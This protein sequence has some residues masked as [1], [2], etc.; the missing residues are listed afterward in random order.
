MSRLS[1]LSKG[2]REYLQAYWPAN[3]QLGRPDPIP[4]KLQVLSDDE[5]Q[6]AIAA[7]HARLRDLKMEV[8]QYT[9]DELE[10]ETSVQVLALACRDNDQ[11]ATVSFAQDA[12]DLRQNSTPWE[13]GEVVDAWRPWQERRNP[14]RA[15]SADEER[16]IDAAIKK[17]AATTL[18]AFGADTLVS[19]MISS[20]SRPPT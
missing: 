13:R 4:M 6:R 16:E 15:L 11:P 3:P 12:D 17:K 14:T 5:M 7:A 1:E 9:A 8:G 19:Y 10:T 2:R 20:A 18:R